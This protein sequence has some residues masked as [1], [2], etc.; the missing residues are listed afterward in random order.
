LAA[1]DQQNVAP[2]SAEYSPSGQRSQESFDPD[3]LYLP[4]G[5][6]SQLPVDFKYLPEG[7]VPQ[8]DESSKKQ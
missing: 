7:Q 3:G 4:V 2:S 8:F 5:Q 1:Q 6:S